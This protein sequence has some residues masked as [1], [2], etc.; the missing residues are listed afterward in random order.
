MDEIKIIFDINESYEEIKETGE[1]KC[2]IC[3]F[4][5]KHKKSILRHYD[6]ITPCYT[7]KIENKCELCM[8]TFKKKDELN[9]H[10]NRLKKCVEIKKD[11]IDEFKESAIKTGFEEGDMDVTEK[12]NEEMKSLKELNNYLKNQN[13]ILISKYEN[14]KINIYDYLSN[15]IIEQYK[16][17][18]ISKN[19]NH[20]KDYLEYYI[21]KTYLLNNTFENKNKNI[22]IFRN[23]VFYLLE[24]LNNETYKSFMKDIEKNELI[25]S[26]IEDYINYLKEQEINNIDRKIRGYSIRS[27]RDIIEQKICEIKLIN[28]K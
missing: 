1:Y 14:E 12:Y 3:F 8:K 19:K 17:K 2:K 26:L 15:I 24:I 21:L 27:Y 18:K 10:K 11:L 13:D 4:T 22:D 5:T 16:D 25:I 9:K 7:W 28:T 23:K 6:K 20:Y